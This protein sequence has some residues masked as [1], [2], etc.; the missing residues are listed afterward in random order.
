MED[1]RTKPKE[2]I[3]TWILFLILI[4]FFGITYCDSI[5]NGSCESTSCSSFQHQLIV[6]EDLNNLQQDDPKLIEAIKK[7]LLPIPPKGTENV[8]NYF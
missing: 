6:D 8:F 4:I 7:I 3:M 5:E 2:T 1:R